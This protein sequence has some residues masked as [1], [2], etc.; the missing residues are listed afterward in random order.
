M[1]TVSVNTSQGTYPVQIGRGLLSQTGKALKSL[2]FRPS[3]AI[4]ADAQVAGTYGEEVLASLR[5]SGFEPALVGVT[6]GERA[7]NLAEVGPLLSFLAQKRME[8]DS[9]VIALGGGVIG[10]LTGFVASIYLRGV[11]FVQIPTT[12]L[13]M[14]DSSVGGK[15][16]V[17][18]P[19]GKNLVGCFYQPR[20]VVADL[21]T[22]KTLPS[23]EIAAGMAEVIKYGVIADPGLLLQVKSGLPRDW[24][25]IV[26]RCVEIKAEIVTADERETTGRRAWLNFGH[27][28]GHAIE[29]AAGY[30][31]LLHGEAVAIG[32]RAAAHLSRVKLGLSSE[33]VTQIESA[34]VANHL[35]LEARGVDRERVRRALG[36]DKKIQAGVNRWVLVP[37]I[38]EAVL[39]T[40]VSASDVETLLD[41]VVPL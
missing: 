24:S 1:E 27:T 40:D 22:L 28:L 30:G 7:K 41:L 15:T 36:Q 12:L 31:E 23:R 10:D 32:L 16:G 33:E 39:R 14:V 5:A 21:D 4:I 29:A 11:P 6:G 34:L 26:K 8:R 20:L 18:L 3:L 38:G 37:R 17:N 25:T 2:G 35:P 19:E 9:A 13:A